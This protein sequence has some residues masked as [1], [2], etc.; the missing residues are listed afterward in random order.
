MQVAYGGQEDGRRKGAEEVVVIWAESVTLV[1]FVRFV[2]NQ[3]I[4]SNQ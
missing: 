4:V 1:W 3:M 2:V